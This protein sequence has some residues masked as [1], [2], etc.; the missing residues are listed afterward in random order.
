MELVVSHRVPTIAWTEQRGAGGHVAHAALQ[1]LLT[2]A[3]A[4]A[5]VEE[6]AARRLTET[7]DLELLLVRAAG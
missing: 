6:A 5:E 3:D 7:L 1:Y 2:Q 4:G